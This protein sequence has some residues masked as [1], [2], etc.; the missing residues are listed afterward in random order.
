MVRPLVSKL[1]VVTKGRPVVASKVGGIG[2]QIEDRKSGLLVGDPHDLRAFGEAVVSVLHDEEKAAALGHEARRTVVRKF[3]TP[4]HLLAQGRLI[5]EL[6]G[7][8]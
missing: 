3:I 5:T 6:A 8:K 7:A 1:M 4:C 2:D